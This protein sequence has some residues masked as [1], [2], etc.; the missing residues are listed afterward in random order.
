MECLKHAQA[1]AIA[2][3]LNNKR[4]HW[5]TYGPHFRDLH[6]F[7]DEMANSAFEEVDPLGERIRMLGGEPLSTLDEIRGAVT[8]Q[9]SSGQL[10]PREMLE[11]ALRNERATIEDMRSGARLADEQNDPGTNDLFSSLIQNHE[12]YAWFL[13]EAVRQDDSMR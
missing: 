5:Y 7:F 3:Y 9:V 2:L 10:S 6:L 12:K 8:V 1:N 4:Y 13:E 11:E